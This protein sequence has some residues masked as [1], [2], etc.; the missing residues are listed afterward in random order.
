MTLHKFLVVSWDNHEE[1]AFWDEVM[2]ESGDKAKE[3]V[4]DLREYAVV[5]DCMGAA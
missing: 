2:A 1:Q 4:S 3:K 5:V